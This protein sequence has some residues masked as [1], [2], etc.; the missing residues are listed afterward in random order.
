MYI[1][2]HKPTVEELVAE[3]SKGMTPEQMAQYWYEL[4]Q[5]MFALLGKVEP[6]VISPI[7]PT[8]WV[9]YITMAYP[10]VIE[11]KVPDETFYTCDMDSMQRILS[12]DWTN[13]VPYVTDRSDCDKFAN[14][15]YEHLCHYYGITA[16][17]PIWGLMPDLPPPNY[18]AFNAIVF[19]EVDGYLPRLIEPQSDVIFKDNG[20]FGI[21]QPRQTAEYLGILP[22]KVQEK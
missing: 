22:I 2:A 16:C 14:R 4:D 9:K 6:V 18:H 19:A 3:A 15:L 11:L 13:D 20:P 12:K 21:Y 5:Q 7:S 1:A 17:L 10:T 8:D